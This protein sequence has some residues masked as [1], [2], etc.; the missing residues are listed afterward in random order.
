MQTPRFQRLLTWGSTLALTLSPTLASAQDGARPTGPPV[1]NPRTNETAPVANP[2]ATRPQTTAEV[3]PGVPSTARDPAPPGTRSVRVDTPGAVAP[4]GV[5][6]GAVAPGRPAGTTGRAGAAAG[7]SGPGVASPGNARRGNDRV[8]TAEGVVTRIDRAGNDVNG[9]LQRFA[10]DPSQDWTSYISRGAQGVAS[11]NADRPKTN[12]QIKAANEQQHEDSPDS[13]GLMEM[14]I[15]KNTYVFTHARTPDGT[16]HYGMATTS[17]PDVTSSRTGLTNRA[18]AP[19]ATGPMPTNFTN[20]KEGSFVAVRYRK[21]GDVNEVMNLTLIEQPISPT[22]TAPGASSTGT[23]AP[24]TAPA[25][26]GTAPAGTRTGAPAGTTVR[27]AQVPTVPLNPV[28]AD[29]P[30]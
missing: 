11:K 7:N 24:G 19:T 14:A 23:A 9:E 30:R 29:L 6:P 4:G 10:F 28:G 16:D 13:P 12:D 27:P 5:A 25:G 20:L 18:A 1:T 2:A 26:R 21:A 3:L 8:L 22:A 17:S 15:T